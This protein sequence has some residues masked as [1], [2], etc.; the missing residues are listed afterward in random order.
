MVNQRLFS[1]QILLLKII[2][3]FIVFMM[4]TI[5]INAQHLSFM[6]IPINGNIKDFQS[7]L[8][9]KG[10]RVD[11]SKSKDAP[12]GQRVFNGKFQGYN[13][14]I[15]VFYNR[16]TKNVY[17]VEV[18]IYSK[19]QSVIQSILDASMQTIEKKYR[20]SFEE[21]PSFDSKSPHFKYYIYPSNE[22]NDYTGIIHILPS[23]TFY[24]PEN[25]SRYELD[26]FIITFIYED[27]IN[28]AS[29]T[30]STTEP[31]HSRRSTCD[32]PENF[33]KFLYWG[34]NFYK[35]ECY[36][37]SIDYFSWVLDY[38]KYGCAEESEQHYEEELENVIMYL[39]SCQIGRIKTAYSNEYA[40]VYRILDDN[41]KRFKCIEYHVNSDLYHIKL[42]ANDI[43]QQINSLVQLK[44]AYN[45]R[46]ATFASNPIGEYS[47]ETIGTTLPA[48]FGKDRLRGNQFG[49]IEWKHTD[50]ISQFTAYN[51]E[52][53]IRISYVGESS[54]GQDIL[55][56]RNEKEIDDYL[57]FLRSVNT[58]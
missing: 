5:S 47:K 3:L 50:L 10:I 7:K 18:T 29:L 52:L 37:K 24:L 36:D 17:K 4:C 8:T 46:K 27:A 51:H 58:Y 22:A 48:L 54:Y 56:F 2:T 15:E 9:T 23:Y 34:S 49:D 53:R 55:L 40:N 32:E 57:N 39:N 31:S 14:E 35:Q 16:K 28:T 21:E 43:R 25:A 1:S 30:P 44:Q 6:G 41:T 11:R 20:C 45:R 26:G 13:S 33:F 42:D 12:V 19:K 38:F